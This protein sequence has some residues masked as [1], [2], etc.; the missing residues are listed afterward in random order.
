MKIPLRY[1]LG[2]LL[3]RRTGTA[4][5]VVG[6]GLTV[7]IFVIMTALVWGL[8]STFVETGHDN[9]LIVIRQGS[10]NE[11]NSYFGRDL[12]QVVRFLPGVSRG[13]NR[14]PLAFGEIVVNVNHTRID[15]ENSN[16]I[17]RGTVEPALA[18]R[19]E[20]RLVEGR[21]FRGGLRELVASRA[22]SARFPDLALGSTV[23]LGRSDWNV[24]GIFES[25][26]SAYDSE[27]WGDY[28]A[29]AQDWDRPVYSSIILRAESD[30]AAAQI[31]TRIADDQRINL[32][33]I[34]QKQYFSDLASAS[35]GIKLLGNFIA[36]IMGIG[37]CFAAMNMMYGSVMSRTR[38]IATL[39]AIGFRGRSI[40]ASFLLES[41]IVGCLGGILGCLLALP[42][43][44]ISAATANFE[45]FSE[46]LFH[47]K[48]T[49]GILLRGI[50]FAVTVGILGG[51]L[52]ARRAARL[53]LIDLL[54][55]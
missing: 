37:A 32:Q 3:A 48:I 35:T 7:A 20:V 28:G 25:G 21:M 34:P 2:S 12:F 13:E 45:T 47:F 53:R 36:V 17:L 51:Y 30:A 43:H 29:V 46:V 6:I 10:L 18:L 42:M 54:R 55:E 39:R 14:E 4:M 31:R 5:T 1:N 41:M 19:P 49:P 52:P 50:L 23:H 22:M 11:T 16:F 26:G 40:L 44:G 27:A 38:E 33:A 15:G 9:Q 8:E 24:V